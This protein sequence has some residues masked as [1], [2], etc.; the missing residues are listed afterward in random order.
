MAPLKLYNTLTRKKEIFKPISENLVKIYTCGPTVYSF[1]HVGNL[2]AYIFSDI[3]KRVL[4][5]NM[6]KVKHI[7]NVTDVGHLTSDSDEGEDK[8]ELASKKEKKSAKELSNFYLKEFLADFQKLNLIK[9]ERF[10][11]ATEHIKEQ[12]EMIKNIEEKSYTYKTSDGIYF[13]TS[14]FKDYGKLSRKKINELEAGKRVPLKEKKNITDFALWK[15]SKTSDK[16]QQ[17]WES[18]WGVGFPGW[19]I[20]CS[21]MSSKYLGKKFDIHT[22]GIDHIPI[23]HENEIAQSETAFGKKPWV[24]WWMHGEFLEIRGGKMSKS[25]G[26][27]KTL[28][29]L[30]KENINPLAYKYFTYTANYRKPLTWSKESL[31]S[32]INSFKRLKNLTNKLKKE[33]IENKKY[34]KEFEK[35]INDDLDIPGAL[36]ILWKLLRDKKAKGKFE[37]IKKMDEVFGLKLLEKDKLEIP[38]DILALAEERKKSRKNQDWKNSDK[39]RIQLEKKGWKIRDEN[40]GYILDKL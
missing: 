4:Q 13:D 11:K 5:Y 31:D 27:T 30:E 17:E 10:P 22:G 2:R 23:H 12:I 35:R 7:I 26:K 24:N 32:S 20:E 3:L 37:T 14:K 34:L 16:R 6:L 39:L 28:K 21:A 33:G 1:A 9:P 40:N 8:L 29:Q 36:A 38:K 15:F 25:K 19:H 18:P